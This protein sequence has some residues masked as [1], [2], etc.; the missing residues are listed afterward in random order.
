[1]E[2]KQCKY[3]SMMIPKTAVFCP[4]CR[5]KVKS[6]TGCLLMIIGTLLIVYACSTIFSGSRDKYESKVAKSTPQN[7]QAEQEKP[8]TW[9]YVEDTEK[10]QDG[11]IKKAIL[12]SE[13]EIELDF[14]YQGP[15]RALL[16]LR[17]HP[18]YGSDAIIHIDRGQF[19]CRYDN[20][21]VNIRFDK[22]KSQKF[23]TVEPSDHSSETLFISNY[24]RFLSG[25]KKSK[26]VYVEAEFFQ[27]GYRVLEFNTAGLKW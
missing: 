11:K 17:K 23:S 10:M 24:P 26:K 9:E 20:C 27:Q 15:Q 22:G 1:M 18:R 3:C 19:L 6:P 14:P 13:N 16:I 12:L 25:L 4:F 8:R 7:F 5:K 21:F 2:E